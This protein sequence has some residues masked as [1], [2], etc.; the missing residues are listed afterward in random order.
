MQKVVC[1]KQKTIPNKKTEE[2]PRELE[3]A[4]F[5]LINEQLFDAGIISK[6]IYEE[7]KADIDKL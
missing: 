6:N 2:I 3:I 1:N 7:V 4:L 5:H